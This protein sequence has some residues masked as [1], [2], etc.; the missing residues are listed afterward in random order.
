MLCSV[1]CV[2]EVVS[3]LRHKHGVNAAVT[4]LGVCDYV[5]SVRMGVKRKKLSGSLYS[6]AVRNVC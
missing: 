3:N 1:D 5:V 2:K 6:S 4:Q